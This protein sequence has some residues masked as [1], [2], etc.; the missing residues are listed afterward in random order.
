ME[1]KQTRKK[2][3][4]KNASFTRKAFQPRRL[5]QG[6]QIFLAAK[7]QNQKKYTKQP[8]NVP[9]GHKIYQLAINYTEWP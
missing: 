8:Q 6:C 9:N 1:R 5:Q 3:E 4:E 2:S 7:Y